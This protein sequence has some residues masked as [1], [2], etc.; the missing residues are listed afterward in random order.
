MRPPGRRKSI[1]KRSAPMAVPR[2]VYA[3]ARATSTR[4]RPRDVTRFSSVTHASR[5]LRGWSV[6][7][8]A[9][10]LPVLQDWR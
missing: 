10:L 6:S 3:F 7:E 2:A 1:M 5:L 9:R 4:T 8:A